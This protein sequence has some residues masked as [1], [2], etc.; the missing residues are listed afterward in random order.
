MLKGSGVSLDWRYEVPNATAEAGDMKLR[1]ALVQKVPQAER[2]DPS[3]MRRPMQAQGDISQMS[4]NEAISTLLVSNSTVMERIGKELGEL[5]FRHCDKAEEKRLERIG[6]LVLAILNRHQVVFT[7]DYYVAFVLGTNPYGVPM[8]R[9]VHSGV[10]P[11]FKPGCDANATAKLPE[12]ETAVMWIHHS[13]KNQVAD[14]IAFEVSGQLEPWMFIRTPTQSQLKVQDETGTGTAGQSDTETHSKGR[15]TTTSESLLPPKDHTAT[16]TLRDTPQ[17]TTVEPTPVPT[18][19]PTTA[20]PK[21]TR[22]YVTKAANK[23]V[24]VM[25]IGSNGKPQNARLYLKSDKFTGGSGVNGF[26]VRNLKVDP[27][28]R[29]IY[30]VGCGTDQPLYE[31]RI[32]GSSISSVRQVLTLSDPTKGRGANRVS[33]IDDDAEHVYFSGSLNGKSGIL[34]V[35]LSDDSTTTVGSNPFR[36]FGALQQDDCMYFVTDG[37][38]TKIGIERQSGLSASCP[39]YRGS[40]FSYTLGASG[41]SPAQRLVELHNGRLWYVKQG[42]LSSVPFSFD[43]TPPAQSQGAKFVEDLTNSDSFD[44]ESSQ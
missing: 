22:V 19:E 30:W 26:C 2:L 15:N 11:K 35:K 44:V 42:E 12:G 6:D 9:G 4:T 8:I 33:Y 13:P 43:R 3:T 32:T 23:E 39:Y 18:P 20:A 37:E 24:W 27:T 41:S 17:P 34:K 38:G 16:P 1:R 31:A 29:K 21:V 25:E 36:F 10:E 40:D 7:S 5:V 14:T 28:N